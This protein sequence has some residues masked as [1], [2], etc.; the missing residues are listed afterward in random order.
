MGCSE[1]GESVRKS[2]EAVGFQD[3]CLNYLVQVGT[4]DGSIKLACRTLGAVASS[5]SEIGLTHD[6][7]DTFCAPADD[8]SVRP[9]QNSL[10]NGARLVL[11]RSGS[12]S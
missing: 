12:H 5:S 9:C 8:E 7:R 11:L 4:N 3:P 10:S 2:L 6:A 1:I